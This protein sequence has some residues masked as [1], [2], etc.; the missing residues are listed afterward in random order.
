MFS[1][2]NFIESG[3]ML[4]SLF[5]FIFV[6]SVRECSNF[7]LLHIAVQFSQHHL[8]KRLSFLHCVFLLFCH[9]LIDYRCVGL[10]QD[11]LPC[12]IDLCVS[13]CFLIC[14]CAGI[15]CLIT[16][17]LQYDLKLG[18]MLP[19]ALFFFLKLALAVQGLY[20]C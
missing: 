18:S 4:K 10:S 17:A 6:Y 14:F 5:H 11:F 3:L 13:V 12:S 8:L 16:V 20:K 1:P 15:Y 7:I 9:R 2:M 19:L